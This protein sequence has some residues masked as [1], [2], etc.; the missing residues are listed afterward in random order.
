MAKK[1][2]SSECS[3]SAQGLITIQ[4]ALLHCKKLGDKDIPEV[5]RSLFD[6]DEI[7]KAKSNKR[8][9]KYFEKHGIVLKNCDDPIKLFVRMFN[10]NS[11]IDALYNII[12]NGGAVSINEFK[13]TGNV[14]DFCDLF[15]H[16]AHKL[17]K[18]QPP[19]KSNNAAGDGEI[20]FRFILKEGTLPRAKGDVGISNKDLLEVKCGNKSGGHADSQLKICSPSVI[21]KEIDGLFGIKNGGNIDYAL[22]SN[23]CLFNNRMKNYLTLGGSL[24]S[25]AV[26]IVDGVCKQYEQDPLKMNN[27]DIL[28][29]QVAS[30]LKEC[31]SHRELADII[32]CTQLYLYQLLEGFK[33]FILMN[34]KGDYFF[35]KDRRVFAD[36]KK[37]LKHIAFTSPYMNSGKR[38]WTG[39]M[40]L[41]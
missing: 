8:V 24:H 11:N 20:F 14:F 9:V 23:I 4:S 41:R 34:S 21:Y 40:S 2:D 16:E 22:K 36:Y 26:A 1:N 3:F 35:I 29:S 39:K 12:N 37:I 5:L 18:L 27:L 15:V 33:Y 10:E 25:V 32:N 30:L 13:E 19:G 17:M 6:L 7:A 28:Y 31:I 38:D